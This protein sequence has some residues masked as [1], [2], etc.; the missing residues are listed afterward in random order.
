[1]T[2][3]AIQRLGAEL[4]DVIGNENQG[5]IAAR[6]GLKR[7]RLVNIMSGRTAWPEPE[8]FNRLA[9]A[10]DVPVTRLLRAAGVDIPETRNEDIEWLASQLDDE[11]LELLVHLG[12]AL[13]PQHRRRP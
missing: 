6:A 8:V 9:R 11:G 4:R 2:L 7:T 10:L 3:L 13:L 1:V 5:E 12:R